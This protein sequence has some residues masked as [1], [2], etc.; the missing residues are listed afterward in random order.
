MVYGKSKDLVKRSQS[1]KKRLK[2]QVIHNMMVV[3]EDWHQWYIIFLIK[4]LKGVLLL[5]MSSIIN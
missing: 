4:S 1:D 3:R 5:L 2:L